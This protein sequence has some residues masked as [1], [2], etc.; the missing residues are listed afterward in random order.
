MKIGE[1]A[2]ATQTPVETIRFYE[3][4]QLLPVPQRTTSNYRIYTPAHG[5][6]LAFIR[7]CRSLDMTLDEIRILLRFKDQPLESCAEVNALLDAHIG[8]VAHR[9]QE[10]K[11]LETHLK[12]LRRQCHDSP[13]AEHC[14][15]LNELTQASSLAV[16]ATSRRGGDGHVHGSHAPGTRAQADSP[17]LSDQ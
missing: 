9:I 5:E 3:R 13:D 12:D 1:L 14:G 15:I 8:H 6:R 17:A 7:H 4:E 10:L 16:G 2:A 11:T